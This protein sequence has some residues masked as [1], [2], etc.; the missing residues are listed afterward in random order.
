MQMQVSIYASPGA[1]ARV[2]PTAH[3]GRMG[4]AAQGAEWQRRNLR[5][6]CAHGP[7]RRARGHVYSDFSQCCSAFSRSKFGSSGLVT[8]AAV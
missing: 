8:T 2:S 5:E 6:R 3:G 4:S 7:A 1:T